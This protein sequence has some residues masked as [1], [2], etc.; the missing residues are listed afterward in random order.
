MKKG[1]NLNIVDINADTRR[2]WFYFPT[3]HS[4]LYYSMDSGY[5]EEQHKIEGIKHC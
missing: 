4:F 1:N 5:I 3:F 2:T